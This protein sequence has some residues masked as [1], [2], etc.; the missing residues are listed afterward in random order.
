MAAAEI[1]PFPGHAKERPI[2]PHWDRMEA[3]GAGAA[4]LA[5]QPRFTPY[6]QSERLGRPAAADELSV[7]TPER[8]RE[9]LL[10]QFRS[11]QNI[12]YFTELFVKKIPPSPSRAFV[13]DTLEDA[14][15]GYEQA[16]DLVYSDPLAE[17]GDLRAALNFWSEIRR[18]NRAFY[19][20][21]MRFLRDKAALIEGHQFGVQRG[22]TASEYDD[23]PYHF[24]MFVAD[25]LRPPGMEHFNAQPWY[26]IEE[27]RTS[28]MISDPGSKNLQRPS[29]SGAAGRETFCGSGATTPVEPSGPQPIPGVNPEDWGWDQG[30]PHRTPEQ[31]M[32]EYWG[33]GATEST[34]LGAQ[35][36]GGESYG[37]RYAWGDKWREN[38]G[39][40]FMRYESIPFWQHTSRHL[41][42]VERDIEETL[43]NSSRELGNH[44][45]RWDL[46]RLR[47]PRGE[48]YR[49]YGPRSGY[50]ASGA[51]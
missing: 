6:G 35:E 40:R 12:Q 4:D 11:P 20:S 1:S 10:S 25:S 23:E 18:L 27:D 38:G 43:G 31:A 15:Y 8:F 2:S 50:V 44:V 36:M 48:E 42:T 28:R 49:R 14:I 22:K 9:R 37:D 47:N 39:T 24:R 46:S 3:N 30:D 16:E 51:V 5:D 19:E 33:E 26:G 17:R 41:D 7:R 29:A 21:R 32:A 45:R 34:R 13:L